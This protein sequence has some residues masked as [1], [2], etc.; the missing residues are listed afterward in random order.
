MGRKD[1]L[2]GLMEA[3][4]SDPPALPS[5]SPRTT[6]GAIGAVS[7]SIADLK[8]R[9]IIEV[10]ADI[11][12]HAGI[13]DRL[14]DDPKGIEELAASIAEYGQ[15]VPV[16][17]RHSPNEEG[18][19]EVVYGRRRVLALKLL[20]Q[21]IK[22]MIRTI[23]DRD[24][25]VAQGQEN[26]L[27]R[28]LS[29]IEKAN[30]ARQMVDMGFERKVVCDALSIDKTL[31]SRMLSIIDALPAKIV[32]AIGS[33]PSFGRERWQLL[34]QHARGR[35]VTELAALITGD[36]SD[37]RFDALL[38]AL[39][40]PSRSEKP[41]PDVVLDAQGKRL[42]TLDRGKTRIR[43]TLDTEDDQGFGDWLA[44]NLAEI[45][46]DYISRGDKRSH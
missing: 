13:K 19:Y 5:V 6:K 27:R 1:L 15:Q 37:A 9:A 4:R 41:A 35:T 30:F 43:L 26:S 33:A 36:S 31:I 42:A 38:K 25:V 24:L 21:P 40:T 7:Q 44:E 34:A 29:F 2:K 45:H 18:R 32:Q 11:I 39:I 3:G 12:D 22:A 23:N 10:P 28:D 8:S 17:L 14:D 46:R 20:R 16:L